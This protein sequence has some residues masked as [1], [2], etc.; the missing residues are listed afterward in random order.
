[1]ATCSLSVVRETGFNVAVVLF[2]VLTPG[3]AQGSLVTA[4]LA[5]KMSEYQ[6]S[7]DTIGKY[8]CFAHSPR[9]FSNWSTLS[10][11]TEA[12]SPGPLFWGFCL[13]KNIYRFLKLSDK[14]IICLT[15]HLILGINVWHNS[16]TV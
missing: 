6:T 7:D 4:Q 15:Y 2:K 8:R 14:M 3:N 16:S 11:S 13:F 1:M 5:K 12:F 10:L 9:E